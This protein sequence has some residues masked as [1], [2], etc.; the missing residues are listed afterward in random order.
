[1]THNEAKLFQP[2]VKRDKKRHVARN[3]QQGIQQHIFTVLPDTVIKPR[4]AKS[5]QSNKNEQFFHL[6]RT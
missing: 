3:G 4:Q 5:G 1:M 6:L 2:S